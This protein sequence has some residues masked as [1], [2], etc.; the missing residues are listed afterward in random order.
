MSYGMYVDMSTISYQMSGHWPCE[1]TLVLAYSHVRH[2]EWLYALHPTPVLP[3]AKLNCPR[4]LNELVVNGECARAA[5]VHITWVG[6]VR[7][8]EVV[9]RSEARHLVSWSCELVAGLAVHVLVRRATCPSNIR[10]T[11]CKRKMVADPR[12]RRRRSTGGGDIPTGGSCQHTLVPG[13]WRDG[14]RDGRGD[15]RDEQQRECNGHEPLIR[16]VCF[17]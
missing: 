5:R 1:L 13:C 3:H 2:S 11:A 14:W 7:A 12:S 15:L 16:H 10:S 17:C 9:V 8:V 6:L 4:L